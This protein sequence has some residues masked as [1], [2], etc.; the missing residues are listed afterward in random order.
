MVFF[1]EIFR[2]AFDT[3]HVDDSK[4]SHFINEKLKHVKSIPKPEVLS[5]EEFQKRVRYNI[6][7][8]A[9]EI[10]S[11]RDK[12]LE[13]KLG[14]NLASQCP[15]VKRELSYEELVWCYKRNKEMIQSVS[16][17]RDLFMKEFQKVSNEFLRDYQNMLV[18]S[19]PIKT[20]S[21]LFTVPEL[22]KL[23]KKA[24]KMVTEYKGEIPETKSQIVTLLNIE[25]SISHALMI[26]FLFQ[27]YRLL[28]RV[29]ANYS[30][31]SVPLYDVV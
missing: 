23:Y 21:A 4:F 30:G 20:E 19:K 9:Q 10:M 22:K 13:A 31:A 11:T 14:T 16:I 3:K 29:R 6:F 15:S 27:T 25:L 26:D 1:T 5:H 8:I 12:G 2:M 18:G 17:F 28:G 24:T 7:T